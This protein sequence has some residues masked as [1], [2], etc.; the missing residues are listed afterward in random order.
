[1]KRHV[2]RHVW[3]VPLLAVCSAAAFPAAA[4]TQT[5][6]NAAAAQ[7][8]K[9]AD[10]ALNAQYKATSGKLS[11]G[12]RTL[13][14]NAQRSWIGFRDQEC[15]YES[16]GVQGGSAY[17]MVYSGCLKRLTDERTRQL[18]ALGQCQEGDL[19]CPR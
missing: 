14:R 7:G 3:F 18:K 13:L 8:A 5:D 2:K 9:A 12:S 15:K 16:S 17:P 11:A 4:Q 19:S 6:M 1:V 10:Q